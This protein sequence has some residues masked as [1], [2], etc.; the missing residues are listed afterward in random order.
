MSV[1]A[2]AKKNWLDQVKADAIELTRQRLAVDLPKLE[3]VAEQ[4]N[5]QSVPAKSMSATDAQAAA[6]DKKAPKQNEKET[7]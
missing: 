7:K 6:E 2:E 5:E 1:V 4:L 3:K